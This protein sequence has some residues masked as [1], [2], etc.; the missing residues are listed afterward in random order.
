M[1]CKIWCYAIKTKT[2]IFDIP[3]Q[4]QQQRINNI[5][6]TKLVYVRSSRREVGISQ[7]SKFA[8][9][10]VQACKV[11]ETLIRDTLVKHLEFTYTWY[12]YLEGNK[13]IHDSQHGFRT[14]RSVAKTVARPAVLHHSTSEQVTLE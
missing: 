4:P 11:F 9:S 10:S 2:T 12:L 6:V 14:G 7:T 1:N 5:R 3:L 8:K 13:L